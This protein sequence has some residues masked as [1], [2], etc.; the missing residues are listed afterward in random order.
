[1]LLSCH[2][3]LTMLNFAM[4]KLVGGY[5]GMNTPIIQ[6]MFLFMDLVYCSDQNTNLILVNIFFELMIFI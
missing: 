4:I 2:G 6:I 5:Y 3:I 1:M